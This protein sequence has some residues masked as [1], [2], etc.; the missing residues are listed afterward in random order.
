[1]GLFEKAEKGE[2]TLTEGHTIRHLSGL[3]KD[4]EKIVSNLAQEEEKQ[5]KTYLKKHY[6]AVY[7]GIYKELPD[8]SFASVNQKVIEKALSFPW[9]GADF[10]DAIW[11]NKT[12]LSYTLNATLTRSLVRGTSMGALAK[13][14]NLSLIHI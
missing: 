7:D 12:L 13:E 10:S 6:K 8:A 2:I 5:L 1:M 9:S 14:I 3:K 4:I 11:K